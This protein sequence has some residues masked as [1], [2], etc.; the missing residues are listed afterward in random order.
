MPFCR[1]RV[2]GF[3]V[4][5]A[6]VPLIRNT[7]A[8]QFIDVRVPSKT[9][10]NADW[11][12]VAASPK[13]SGPP[14]PADAPGGNP[15]MAVGNAAKAHRNRPGWRALLLQ[16]GRASARLS[17]GWGEAY[18]RK[19]VEAGSRSPLQRAGRGGARAPARQGGRGR[20]NGFRPRGGSRSMARPK[21]A[22]DAARSM[23]MR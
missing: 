5:F 3:S 8:P 15:L 14:L 7:S 19:A 22:W 11:A 23:L 21:S 9:A 4:N 12:S 2:R 16:D 20:M 18:D 1:P 13:S 10:R 17:C 6:G